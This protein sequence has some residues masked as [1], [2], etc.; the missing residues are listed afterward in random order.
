MTIIVISNFAQG[1]DISMPRP[2][3]APKAN[4][5]SIGRQCC[6][7]SYRVCASLAQDYRIPGIAGEWPPSCVNEGEAANLTFSEAIWKRKR[8]L[9]NAVRPRLRIKATH[10]CPVC[11]KP[12]THAEYDHALGLW[13]H[14]QE[15]IRHLE[16]ERAELHRKELL[17]QKQATQ[18]ER[19]FTRRLK[20]ERAA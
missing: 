14:K 20:H 3:T 7:P 10:K 15:H 9:M 13:R 12:L 4:D 11:G 1:T 16:A 8:P 19:E 6:P 18:R 2:S 5:A 17:L